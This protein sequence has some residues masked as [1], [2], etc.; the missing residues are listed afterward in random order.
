MRLIVNF[1]S[2]ADYMTEFIYWVIYERRVRLTSKL[3]ITMMCFRTV[4]SIR[5]TCAKLLYNNIMYLV[6]IFRARI[7]FNVEW[8][9]YSLKKYKISYSINYYS[10]RVQKVC[11]N[12]IYD[13]LMHTILLNSKCEI[14][15]NNTRKEKLC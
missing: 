3:R 1:G 2:V 15:Y 8:N 6:E 5:S 14:R 11:L 4:K 7:L 10:E 13:T 9:V 12:L